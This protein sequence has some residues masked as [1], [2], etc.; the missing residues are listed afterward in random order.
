MKKLRSL[1]VILLITMMVFPFNVNAEENKPEKGKEPVK[2]YVFRGE[3]CGYCKAALE[4]FQS[5]E[6]EYGDYFDIVDYEV[7]YNEENKSLMEEVA[8]HMGDTA[9]GVPYI[10]VGDYT[11]P[12]GFAADTVV[13]NDT[14]KTMGD[15]MIDQILEVY[16]SN[17]RYDVMSELKNKPDYSNVVGIVSGVI[18]IGLVAVAVISRKQNS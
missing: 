17:N 4:W 14:Q 2:V 3:T 16:E 18:I 6:E 7:W 11:Y 10:I 1:L 15:Q 12:N 9:S 13:D 8:T 5:I